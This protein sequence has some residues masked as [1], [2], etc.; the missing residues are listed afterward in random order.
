[1]PWEDAVKA[2]LANDRA[3]YLHWKM[4]M[5]YIKQMNPLMDPE[6]QARQIAARKMGLVKDPLGERLPDDLWRQCIKEAELAITIATILKD[7]D[8]ALAW[9]G[10]T[11][12]VMG[13]VCLTRAEAEYLRKWAIQLCIERDEL[14]ARLDATKK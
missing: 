1:M 4:Q 5:D 2:Q 7:I 9:R 13:H 8:D 12:K 11:D 3:E 10:P 14:L 6:Y